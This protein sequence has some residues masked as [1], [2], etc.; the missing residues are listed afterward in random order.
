MRQNFSNHCHRVEKMSHF[1]LY[2]VLVLHSVHVVKLHRYLLKCNEAKQNI[3]TCTMKC[4][5]GFLV[6]IKH[7]IGSFHSFLCSSGTTVCHSR[8]P[9]CWQDTQV[10]RDLTC[11]HMWILAIDNVWDTITSRINTNHFMQWF[12]IQWNEY[13]LIVLIII[14]HAVVICVLISGCELCCLI[15]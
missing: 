9:R 2:V 10:S 6:N 7:A 1:F 4:S 11:L 5:G 15:E 14:V 13:Y 3:V 12:S 8:C